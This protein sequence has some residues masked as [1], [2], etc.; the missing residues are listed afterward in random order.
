M[1]L[2]RRIVCTLLGV[3]IFLTLLAT[4]SGSVFATSFYSTNSSTSV[5]TPVGNAIMLSG[6][7]YPSG[8]PAAVV[9]NADDWLSAV[10]ASVLARAYGGPLLLCSSSG[11]S[12]N[13][14]TELKRLNPGAVYVVGLSV[15]VVGEIDA[16][17][18]GLSPRPQ[19]VGLIGA[20]AYETAVLVA[21]QVKVKLGTV[22]RVVLVPSDYSGGVLAGSAMAAGNG[23][24]ILL[25]PTA[26]PLPK[27]SGDAI[28]EL[29]A[30]DGICLGTTVDPAISGFT[31]D[32][33]ITGTISGSDPDGRYSLCTKTAEYAVAQGYASFA[34]V[35][36]TE[37][38]DRL[39]GQAMSAYIAGGRG[40]LIP[41]AATGLSGPASTFMQAHGREISQVEVVGLS[42]SLFRQIK[43]LNSPRVN[44]VSPN[45]GP[46]DGGTKVVVTGTGLD[47]A[48]SV[49]MGKTVVPAANWKADSS[50]QLTIMSTPQVPGEGPAEVI[51][52][53]YWGRSPASVTDLYRFTDGRPALP[54]DKVVT[55]ALKYV[56]VPY[57]WA[58]ASP[59][60]GFDC[61]GLTSYVYGKLGFSL[62]HYSRAQAGYGI[63]VSQ[64]ML[65]P[66]DL[67]FFS[68]PISHVAIY[69]GGGLM[70]N[71]PRSGDLV[72]IENVYRSSYA[73]ARRIYWPYTRYQDN[74]SLI[75]TIGSW[76]SSSASTAS[77]GTFRWLNSPGVMTVKFSGTYLGWIGKRA[78]QYGKARV[79]VDGGTPVIVDLYS[80][81]SQY[82]K[83]VWDTGLLAQGDHTVSIEW[84]GTKNPSSSACNIAVD[85]FDL[86]GSLVQAPGPERHQQDATSD[87]KYAGIWSTSSTWSASGGSFTYADSPG[88]SVNVA[89][90]GTYLAWYATKGPGYGKAQ[91]SLDGGTPF[92]VDLYSPYNSYKQR[93]YNTGLLADTAHTLSIYWVGQKNPAAWG[94]KIDVDTFDLLGAHT[95]ASKAPAILWRYQQ[96]DS[97]LTYLG[98]WTTA[99][100]WS[101]SGG[102]FNSTG[103][104][105]AAV[106][107]NFT[108]TSV[109]LYART[110]PWY[111]KARVCLDGDWSTAQLVDF[112]SPTTLYKQPV[113]ERTGLSDDLHTLAIKCIGETSSS[114]NAIS[115]DALDITGYLG[116][117]PVTTRYQQ[118][119]VA[120]ASAYTGTWTTSATTWLASG[121]NYATVN[122][123][124]AQVVV[125]FTGSYLAWVATTAPWYGKAQ[126]T[127][128]GGVDGVSADI[129]TTVDLYTATT[130]WKR[131]VYNTGLLTDGLHKLTITWLGTKYWR[132]TGTTISVDAFD[133][134]GTLTDGAATPPGPTVTRY[135]QT[136]SRV[137]YVGSW[138]TTST[139]AASGGDFTYTNT[140]A[141][142][143]VGFKGTSLAWIAKKSS[144]YGIATVTLDDKAPVQVDLYSPS[145]LTL[146]Q[147]SVYQTGELADGMHTLTIEWTGTKN[148]A[149]T[150]YNIGADAF[151]IVGE[152]VQASGPIRYEENASQIAYAGTWQPN[153]WALYA[154]GGRSVY[155]NSPECSATISFE[156]TYIAWV[157]K[158]SP[159]YGK[160]MV[161]MDGAPPVIVDLFS[162]TEVWQRRVWNSGILPAG[163]HTLTIQWSWGR[164]RYATD[165]NLCLDAVEVVGTLTQATA[166]VMH[167]DPKLVA[168][169]PGHQLYANNALE[170]VGPGSTT[171]KAKVSAG[172]ASVNT[173]S[174]ESALVLDVG[175]KVRDSLKAYGLDVLMT[176]ETQSVDISNSE[177]A[178]LANEAGA[179]LFVRIH[180][181]GS[182]TS[183]VNGILMLYP[184]TIAGWT[185]DIAAE[186]QRG[187]TLAQQELLKAT[188]A[189]DRGFSARSDLAGFN[190]SNVPTFLAEIGLMTNPTEDKLLATDAYQDK[191]V[192]GL[193]K[194][195][196]CFLNFY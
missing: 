95:A 68:N 32:K 61:S 150:D 2:N 196:L 27:A 158:M 36:V 107:V 103:A 188:G 19:I 131:Q 30:T 128:V 119:D 49:I 106:L 91:V 17:L 39:G 123:T 67:V 63:A 16:A 164:N 98:N 172:T 176:R 21:R 93:V 56:G 31:V 135:E 57:V 149:A 25:T 28:M 120:L 13:V 6:K 70:I 47:A 121:G 100:T 132:S 143:V 4:A 167:S 90:D 65:L 142:L 87:F 126:V 179:E 125:D 44:L 166:T 75:A 173:G 161:S 129:V 41:T 76:G 92:L 111:G 26:G 3:L 22:S 15:T 78:P 29:G 1:R 141:K 187:A 18:A 183:S 115:L 104:T 124:G 170:P 160:A 64:D 79:T 20:D 5:G 86:I 155:A 152:L 46:V 178:K 74:N 130:G 24:P 73:T 38:Y 42:W 12:A 194:S 101:A 112:Y 33:T 138:Y 105:G 139:A 9:T 89:F 192:S 162:V 134:M 40:V 77:G 59:A 159:L 99:A 147:Q 116:P 85:A 127:L 195:I 146:Y 144:V 48:S 113:Y 84:T 110:T 54:G 184:A 69:I 151:D 37:G 118:N 88:A 10:G 136:D 185:D 182:T 108:G 102:S 156:G 34:R 193:T 23:W 154:S 11:L 169:D 8:A 71:A 35:G 140:A 133:V 14:A 157:T 191:I 58:G 55:E 145:A 81:T 174:P 80:P 168:I 94:T 72:T 181:D 45:S 66:G 50:T 190:W 114:G 53:N 52:Q 189:K 180:A 96:T 109:K 165:T 60:G 62:P 43:S 117:A 177:R 97:R 186:S 175:L 82:Q 137:G 83:S 148:P 163:P 153:S 7:A 171:M 122:A 51:V